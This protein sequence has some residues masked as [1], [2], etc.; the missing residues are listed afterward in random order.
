ML[1]LRFGRLLVVDRAAQR[2]QGGGLARWVCQCDCG[3]LVDIPGSRLRQG[4]VKSCGCFR[5]DRAGGL[6]RKH[7]KSKTPQYCMFYDARK[8]AAMLSLPFDI[9]PE[10]IVVPERCPVLDIPLLLVGSRDNRPSLDRIIPASGYTKQN[11]AVISFR[12]NRV[13]SDAT[14]DELKRILGYLER[15]NATIP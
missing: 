7:G 2:L 13:K 10:D 6:Y 4:D 14:A 15:K 3:Q 11:I 8:R 12:A 5:R 9:T 1:G